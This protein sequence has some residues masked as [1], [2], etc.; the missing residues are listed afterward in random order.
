ME[1]IIT[2]Q[3]AA[4]G[5]RLVDG[6]FARPGLIDGNGERSAHG[7]L[8]MFL[9]LPDHEIAEMRLDEANAY[10]LAHIEGIT[11]IQ[12]GVLEYVNNQ[13]PESKRPPEA[14]PAY[15]T[16][17]AHDCL[18]L[19]RRLLGNHWELILGLD[20]L[21]HTY[22][23]DHLQHIPSLEWQSWEVSAATSVALY[24]ATQVSQQEAGD[25]RAAHTSLHNRIL[26]ARS[27]R[28]LLA[29]GIWDKAFEK[30]LDYE[31]HTDANAWYMAR[32]AAARS[33][34][35]FEGNLSRIVVNAVNEIQGYAVY[36]EFGPGKDNP[37]QP[38]HELYFLPKLVDATGNPLSIS[39]L[40]EYSKS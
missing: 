7:K 39:T 21:V 10:L 37:K 24:T 38:T 17:L 25:P 29:W 34:A 19:P 28:V 8:L 22:R 40:K 13:T 14:D 23:R 26:D 32:Y 18:A 6:V 30:F 20:R 36:P 4:E 1:R 12:L 31:A 16:S 2:P 5:I 11:P 15:L 27:S 9:G 35:C 33:T 3:Q